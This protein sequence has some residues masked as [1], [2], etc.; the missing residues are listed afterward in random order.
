[1]H[2]LCHLWGFKFYRD[3]ATREMKV[4]ILPCEYFQIVVR[5]FLVVVAQLVK[6]I[7]RG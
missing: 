4:N 7:I 3:I 5:K 2:V 6:I 1:M